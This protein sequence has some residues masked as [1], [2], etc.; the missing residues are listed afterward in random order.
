MV[1]V[2]ARH[3]VFLGF[4]VGLPETKPSVAILCALDISMPC[5]FVCSTA[6]A[7]K[8]AGEDVA[9]VAYPSRCVR[10]TGL[11]AALSAVRANIVCEPIL[12]LPSPL[13]VLL[14]LVRVSQEKVTEAYVMRNRPASLF[15]RCLH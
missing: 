10:A 6:W 4:G 3:H 7:E 8:W 9:A 13:L 11:P 14:Q 1:S 2:N 12:L 15:T 5:A